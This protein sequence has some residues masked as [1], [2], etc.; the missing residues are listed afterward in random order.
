MCDVI[1][2]II[3]AENDVIFRH[4]SYKSRSNRPWPLLGLKQENGC[5]PMKTVF[6]IEQKKKK[7]KK[8]I[9]CKK[10]LIRMKK[11]ATLLKL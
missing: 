9:L 1:Y 11:T 6:P 4:R 5:L 10:R 8:K 7:K 3:R 2:K